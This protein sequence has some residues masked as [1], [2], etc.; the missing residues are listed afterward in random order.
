MG[1]GC[2]FYGQQVVNPGST[3]PVYTLPTPRGGEAAT[4]VANVIELLS[5][6]AL[7]ITIEHKNSGETAWSS[8]GSFTAITA[9]GVHPLDVSGLKESI[10]WN[11]AFAPGVAAGDQFRVFKSVIWR[12]Y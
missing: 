12:P 7:N 1:C 8:A 3:N 9:A 11:F 4:F 6:V 5:S 2:E 10:R